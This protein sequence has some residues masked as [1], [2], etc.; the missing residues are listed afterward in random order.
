MSFDVHLS[1]DDDGREGKT[2]CS[3]LLSLP[4]LLWLLSLL[5]GTSSPWKCFG[6]FLRILMA[7]VVVYTYSCLCLGSND[8]CGR[9]IGVW[10]GRSQSKSRFY[11]LCDERLSSF[12]H[13]HRWLHAC[14]FIPSV[15]CSRGMGKPKRKT[16]VFVLSSHFP[17]QIILQSVSGDQNQIV[18]SWRYHTIHG[19]S[20]SLRNSRGID[21]HFFLIYFF[22]F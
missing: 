4:S 3:L 19:T 13:F 2:S 9:E 1:P 8:R 10:F 6:L 22:L 20:S 16:K 18:P 12:A 14:P 15:L 21:L 5:F 17:S 7:D 11:S